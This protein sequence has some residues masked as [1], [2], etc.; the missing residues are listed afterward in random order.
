LDRAGIPSALIAT[1]IS[2]AKNVG[3]NRIV[4]GAGVAHVVGNPGLDP[5]GEKA[6]RR[7]LV[8]R[9]LLALTTPLDGQRV[10]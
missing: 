7:K 6:F 5:D 3:A 8:E 1:L 9:A 2:V 10:F 4:S